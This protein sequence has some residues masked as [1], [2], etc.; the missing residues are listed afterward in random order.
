MNDFSYDISCSKEMFDHLKTDDCF[1]ALL[2]LARVINALR[3][4]QKAAIDA[5]T[6]I[7]PAG[8]RSRINA[9]LFAAS[10]LYEGFLAVERLAVHFKNFHS[11]RNGFAVLLKDK[12][13]QYC[14]G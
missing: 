7:G 12:D 13:S 10:V 6:V 11:Y 9:F 4:C 8:A 14:R 5:K 2:T 3:F 1:L